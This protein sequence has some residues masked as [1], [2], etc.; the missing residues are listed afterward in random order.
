VN[1]NILVLALILCVFA[2]YTQ[3]APP[4]AIT[5][6]AGNITWLVQMGIMRQTDHWQ[7]YAG[8]VYYGTAIQKPTDINATG[9]FVNSTNINLT[10]DCDN[11]TY[12]SG[13][14]AFSNTTT[15]PSGLVP[16]D[17]TI[18]DQLT[19]NKSDSGTGTFTTISTFDL[20]SGSIANVPT[21]FPYVN[22]TAQASFFREGYFNQ[23]NDLVFIAQIEQ[24]LAGYNTSFFDFQSLLVAP[25]R[26]T[27]KYNIFA[28]LNFSCP[29][30]PPGPGG[31]SG[32]APGGCIVTWQCDPWGACQPDGFQYRRCF[33]R[34][35]CPNMT[36]RF[37]P[38]TVREC[39]KAPREEL[40][41]VISERKIFLPGVIGNLSLNLSPGGG[42]ILEFAVMNGTFRNNNYISIEDITYRVTTPRIYT[43]FANAHPYPLLL[44]GTGIGGWTDHGQAEAKALDWGV[45]PPEPL[46][47]LKPR[48]TEPYQFKVVPPVMQPKLVDIGISAYSGDFRVRSAIAQFNVEVHPFQVAAE[49][50]QEGVLTLYFVVDNRGKEEK[51]INIEF[52]LNRG[53]STLEAEMLG[54]LRL[55]A[56]S[57]AI[58]GHEYRL[59]KAAMNADRVD[60]ALIA[61]E[62][63]LKAQYLLR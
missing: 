62:E 4:Y 22:E 58:Y 53:R 6:D 37:K 10:I 9:S 63:V 38:P 48:T 33:P 41:E 17:L 43:A 20:P 21:T 39:S 61:K 52:G 49:W 40:P 14:I 60:A 25:N 19:G 16:G 42:Y 45:I 13:Y 44:W 54:V 27:V 29:I 3:A 46:E 47:R 12:V 56:D 1:K 24:A 36:G 11:P 18:L 7:G 15:P 55:P 32:G 26:T 34:F 31:G 23:G 50:K 59:G 2:A 8:R 5:A 57:V 51:D 35:A 30:T 28:D